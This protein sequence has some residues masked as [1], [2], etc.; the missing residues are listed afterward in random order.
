MTSVNNTMKVLSEPMGVD[1]D[2]DFVVVMAV[3]SAQESLVL[4]LVKIRLKLQE[5]LRVLMSLS[6]M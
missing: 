6:H 3:L 2:W 4:I 1:R 5:R